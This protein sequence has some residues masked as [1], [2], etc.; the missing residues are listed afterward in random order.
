MR[1]RDPNR[2]GP[3]SSG[4]LARLTPRLIAV[5][6]FAALTAAAYAV[7]ALTAPAGAQPLEQRPGFF[8]ASGFIIAVVSSIAAL[9]MRLVL[10]RSRAADVDH[11]DDWR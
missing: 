3:R 2:F 6:L 9:L 10:G 7:S 8:A 11:A 5:A 4:G 1:D